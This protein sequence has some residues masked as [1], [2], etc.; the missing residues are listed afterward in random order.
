MRL[1]ILDANPIELIDRRIVNMAKIFVQH[2]WNA[3]V[4]GTTEKERAFSY[5]IQDGITASAV[6]PDQI[7]RNSYPFPWTSAL[8][9]CS[10]NYPSQAVMACDLPALPVAQLFAKQWGAPLIYDAHEIYYEQGNQCGLEDKI[11][12]R[13]IEKRCLSHI[14]LFM[15]VSDPISFLFQAFHLMPEKPK[16]FFNAPD[17]IREPSEAEIRDARR[18]LGIPE[19]GC[20]LIFH[21]GM[22]QGR[23]LGLL[24]KAFSRLALENYYLVYLGYGDVEFF[25]SWA[26]KSGSNVRVFESVPQNSLPAFLCGAGALVI[27][28]P[29]SCLNNMFCWPNKLSDAIQLSVPIIAN[30]ALVS[31]KSLIHEFGI[32]AVVDMTSVDRLTATLSSALQKLRDVPRSQMDFTGARKLYGWETQVNKLEV[33]LHDLSLPGF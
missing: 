33:W 10:R 5:Q 14:D 18:H 28:Y 30:D 27:P 6:P 32:G 8:E 2:G 24:M 25:K 31:V 29:A 13:Y 22:A 16:V 3:Q 9:A 19:G 12:M 15:T 1:L 17:F 20:Y 26:G 7:D 4:I 21:G 11:L 23:N